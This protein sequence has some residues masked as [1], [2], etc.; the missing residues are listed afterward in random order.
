[1][2]PVSNTMTILRG[3]ALA[4]VISAV[5]SFVHTP[6]F[7]P[8]SCRTSSML[9]SA[10][11]DIFTLTVALTREE[12]K[13]DQIM[14]SIENHPTRIMLQKS[15][16]LKLVEMPCIEHAD[17]PDLEAFKKMAEEDPSFSKYEYIVITS[18]ESA[19]VF[20]S[21]VKPSGLSADIAAVGKATKKALTDLG[22]EVSFVPSKANGE[23]MAEELPPVTELGLNN[24]LYPAS[25]KAAETIQENLGLRKDSAFRVERLNTY[26]TVSTTLTQ[27]QLDIANGQ[28]HIACF[29]SPSAVDAWLENIDR[30][31]GIEDL[32]DEEK[33]KT[34]GSQGN[35]VAVCIGS[36]TAKRCLESGRWVSS[37]I[38]YPAEKPG[39]EGW[40]DSCLTAGGD[41]M[42]KNFWGL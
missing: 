20:A 25:A 31:L 2:A 16:N 5:S 37:D 26:D 18:P 10:E 3:V 36:T 33:K 6:S 15:M 24:V 21:S 1:M 39:L 41:V 38:Y 30:A 7:R 14:E 4:S 29:G 35:V 27:E 19:K 28:A 9:A 34:P 23:A 11:T 32:D 8:D 13:N 22:F 17:G 40:T 42:E 12:G